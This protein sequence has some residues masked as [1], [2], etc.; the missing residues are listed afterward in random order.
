[1]AVPRD[2]TGSCDQHGSGSGTPPARGAST[3]G[4]GTSAFAFNQQQQ[5]QQQQQRRCASLQ[6]PLCQPPPQPQHAPPHQH[7]QYRRKVFVGG[8]P[9]AVDERALHAYFEAFG[10]VTDAVVIYDHA[11]QRRSRG[12]GFVTFASE[13]TVEAVLA[14][15]R[16]HVL[17]QKPIDVKSAVPRQ[18][19]ST[20]AGTGGGAGV[21]AGRAPM[22]HGAPLP[23]A[24]HAAPFAQPVLTG[25][26]A[27]SCGMTPGAW[28]WLR[29]AALPAAL[30]EGAGCTGSGPGAGAGEQR[31]STGRDVG[32]APQLPGS[33][34]YALGL[35][36]ELASLA[37]LWGG[38]E[39]QMFQ[40]QL[41]QSQQ[42]QHHQ[43]QR[44]QQQ[45][46]HFQ[47]HHQ[48][49][50]QQRQ[51]QQHL[52]AAPAYGG[53]CDFDLDV[54]V[55]QLADAL[56]AFSRV[57]SKAE[58]C[59]APGGGGTAAAAVHT[60]T[61]VPPKPP[62]QQQHEQRQ[63]QQQQLQQQQQQGQLLRLEPHW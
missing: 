34:C 41:M 45:Q 51:Q 44:F 43:Q 56:R 52:P 19:A 47:Q 12:F 7:M 25:V 55:T 35:S 29:A 15:G 1:M 48:H 50:E 4:G 42:Q 49:P 59:D 8:L 46:Q 63:F 54:D 61:V 58:T 18:H 38:E 13:A 60:A 26:E 37:A 9:P 62:P 53:D 10:D 3:S 32:A 33:L 17:A 30:C 39:Q 40:Q 36:G 31:G 21:G 28:A 14:T 5:Q 11:N 24:A 20:G 22:P 57:A 23:Q 6:P 16:V 27:A 2:D